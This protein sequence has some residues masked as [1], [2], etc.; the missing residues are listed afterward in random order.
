MG[1]EMLDCPVCG[2]NHEIVGHVGDMP[3]LHCPTV[4]K[5]V[6]LVVDHAKGS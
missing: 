6:I 5:S 4:T 1:V 3:I 2:V